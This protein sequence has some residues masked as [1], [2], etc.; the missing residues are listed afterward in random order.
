VEA[1]NPISYEVLEKGTPVLDTSGEQFGTVKEILAV[2]EEDIFEGLILHTHHG[3]RFLHADSIASI[4]RH[5]VSSTLDA[6]AAAALPKPQP[7]PG[8]IEVTP[9]D[10]SEPEGAYKR[11]M[12]FK[13]IWNRLSGNY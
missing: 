13:R 4:H 11:E 2:E 6:A 10:I 7:A 3:D 5:A 9:D 8:E 12:L 1:G